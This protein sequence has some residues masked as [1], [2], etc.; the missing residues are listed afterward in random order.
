MMRPPAARLL[1]PSESKSV[2]S[3]PQDVDR[4]VPTRWV[5][6][7][8]DMGTGLP[9]ESKARLVLQCF[10]DPDAGGLDVSSPTLSQDAFLLLLLVVASRRWKL[11][12]ADIKGAFM[13]SRPVQRKGNS[14]CV[15]PQTVALSR[16]S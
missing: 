5:L 1:T 11:C 15:S 7:E 12:V 14:V 4:T 8:K 6:V 13:T 9:T 10:C 2:R 3:S 16:R